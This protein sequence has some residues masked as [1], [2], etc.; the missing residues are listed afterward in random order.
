VHSD[1]GVPEATA[2]IYEGCYRKSRTFVQRA[3][4]TNKDA[5]ADYTL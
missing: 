5:S 4:V 1:L 3:Q 2:G